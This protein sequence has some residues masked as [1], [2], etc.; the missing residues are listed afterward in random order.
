ME[1]EKESHLNL[2]GIISIQPAA[3][4]NRPPVFRPV[5]N[6]TYVKKS[7]FG[8]AKNPGK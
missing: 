6:S 1:N 4:G 8:M 5:Q 2:A 7:R 3:A